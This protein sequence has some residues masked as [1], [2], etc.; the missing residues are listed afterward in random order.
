MPE[1]LNTSKRKAF[2]LRASKFTMTENVLYQL[3][4]DSILRRCVPRHA[5]PRVIEES[6]GGD[7]GGHF[8]AEIT[9]KKIL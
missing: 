9:I 2:I 5:R 1:G 4:R 6:H 3:G 8:A 7:S